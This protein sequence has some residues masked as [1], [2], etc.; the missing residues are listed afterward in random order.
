MRR[1]LRGPAFR[2]TFAFSPRCSQCVRCIPRENDL[3]STHNQRRPSNTAWI[4]SAAK[5]SATPL[6]FDIGPWLRE[7]TLG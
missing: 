7:E 2:K 3:R 6:G 5:N 4:D 1:E